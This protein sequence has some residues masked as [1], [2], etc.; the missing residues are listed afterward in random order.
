V[1]KT[2]KKGSIFKIEP[3]L[4]YIYMFNICLDPRETCINK[5]VERSYTIQKN[6]LYHT[7]KRIHSIQKNANNIQN[8]KNVWKKIDQVFSHD[9]IYISNTYIEMC[10]E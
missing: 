6:A 1:K 9:I 8:N 7:K 2:Q 10:K 4:L 3:V 5:G